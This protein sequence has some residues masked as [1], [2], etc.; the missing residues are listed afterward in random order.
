MLFPNCSLFVIRYKAANLDVRS[1]VCVSARK[2]QNGRCQSGWRKQSGP[3]G[4]NLVKLRARFSDRIWCNLDSLGGTPVI[5]EFHNVIDVIAQSDEEIK[6]KLPTTLH[7]CL[8][9]SAPLKCLTASYDQGKIMSA[10]P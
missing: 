4:I 2:F 9:G 6:E 8:H 5:P 1:G 7:F 10:E 3:P